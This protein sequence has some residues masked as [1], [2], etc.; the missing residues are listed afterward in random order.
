MTV[1]K[2]GFEMLRFIATFGTASAVLLSAL[3]A[4]TTGVSRTVSTSGSGSGS[5]VRVGQTFVYECAVGNPITVRV[6]GETAWLFL[7]SGTKSLPHVV[8]ASGVRFSD[9]ATS[10]WNKGA[11]ASFVLEGQM[12]SACRNNRARAIWEDAKFRG[13]D[14]RAIGNEPG[15]HLEIY[16]DEKV[17]FTNNYGQDSH[18][19]SFVAPMSDPASRTSRYDLHGDVHRLSIELE[20]TACSDSMSGEPFQTR[21]LLLFDGKEYFGCGRALH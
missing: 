21:V 7:A 4:C 2:Y 17:L 1:R 11:E 3:T 6:E 10:Y 15:W 12:Y 18:Q 9:G 8:S 14:F 16:D 19:F 5:A 13:V 20:G